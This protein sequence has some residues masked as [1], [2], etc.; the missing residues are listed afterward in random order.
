MVAKDLNNTPRDLLWER[1]ALALIL[2]LGVARIIALALNPIELYADESQYWVWSRHLDWGYF[3]KP[4]V[5]AWLIH[6]TTTVFGDSDFAVRLSAPVLHTVTA[7]FLYLSASRLWDPRTGFWTA[8]VYLTLPSIW[9]SGTLITTD[10]PMMCAWAGGLYALLRLRDGAGWAS[11]AGLGFAIGI[12]FLSKYAMLYFGVGLGL[13]MLVD[14]PARRALLNL[15]GA[16]ALAIGLAMLAPNIAWNAAHEFA[17]V[18][19]TVANANWGGD[20]FHPL[21]LLDF[22]YGQWGMFGPFLF[23]LL[24]LVLGG[25]VRHWR[26]QT[27]T[28]R[29]LSLFILPPL[30]TVSIEAFISRAHANW[31]A[32][33][34]VAATLLIVAFLLRGPSWRRLYMY[35]SVGF[36]TALGLFM[37]IL[38]VNPPLVETFGLENAT[39]RIRNWEETV[40]AIVEAGMADDYGAVVFDDRNIFHQTQR[41]GS[42]LDRPIEMWLRYSGAVN[43]AEQEWP[44]VDGY[45]EPVL[46][47]SFRPLEV[48]RMRED[49]D[50]FEPAGTLS[51]PLDGDKTRDFTLWRA[52]HY[53]RV[54]RDAAY[55]ERWLARD[56]AVQAGD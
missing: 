9:I 38:I 24:V 19:H 17:T 46:I 16:V 37:T 18:S 1:G 11:V 15:R 44:L 56:A 13:A 29:L 49:F 25:I 26:E 35:G 53:H 7:S 10:V 47:V 21:E 54:T 52:Q 31:A 43:H 14:A 45:D 5:I 34:Y 8:L 4:P 51:I 2:A 22:L 20:L 55:E 39:K 6:L 23:C 48:A 41:Y 32:G 28:T 40:D 3:S 50:S 30:V 12:G 27:A 42:T 36:H 33:T